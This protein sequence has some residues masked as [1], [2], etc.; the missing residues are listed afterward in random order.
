MSAPLT[1]WRQV[2]TRV[3]QRAASLRHARL[4]KIAGGKQAHKT[5]L[6]NAVVRLMEPDAVF[7][8]GLRKRLAPRP[9]V[10]KGAPAGWLGDWMPIS[11]TLW[12]AWLNVHHQHIENGEFFYEKSEAVDALIDTVIDN[13]RKVYC[14]TTADVGGTAKDG[15]IDPE[16][17]EIVSR[18]SESGQMH[19][20]RTVEWEDEKKK[21]EDEYEAALEQRRQETEEGLRDLV[22][23]LYEHASK[24]K[25]PKQRRAFWLICNGPQLRRACGLNYNEP[26]LKGFEIAKKCGVSEGAVSKRRAEFDE[27]TEQFFA[28]YEA[29]LPEARALTPED[30][31]EVDMALS[32]DEPLESAVEV[33][34]KGRYKGDA[35]EL[36]GALSLAPVEGMLDPSEDNYE[37]VAN[38]HARTRANERVLGGGGGRKKFNEEELVTGDDG[39]KH[40]LNKKDLAEMSKRVGVERVNLNK[41]SAQTAA[42]HLQRKARESG[43]DIDGAIRVLDERIARLQEEVAGLKAVRRSDVLFWAAVIRNENLAGLDWIFPWCEERNVPPAELLGDIDSGLAS[44]IIGEQ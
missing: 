17:S 7:P 27:M 21:I 36:D 19:Y 33:I 34:A 10:A 31:G 2:E 35:A 11:S 29:P 39:R 4:Y 42:R 24:I 43:K 22:T 38:S 20:A 6:D 16:M 3:K 26:R 5:V 32:L 30:L 25:C 13:E 37:N 8:Y 44:T 18:L 23:V 12:K 40:R 1:T 28:R 14:E 41:R 15:K 9:L